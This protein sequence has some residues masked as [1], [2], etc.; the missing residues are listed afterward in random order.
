MTANRLEPVGLSVFVVVATA[1]VSPAQ[2]TS[3]SLLSGNTTNPVLSGNSTV[4]PARSE[5]TVSPSLPSSGLL[6][7]ATNGT[8]QLTGMPCSGP[9]ALS[10]SGAGGLP[11]HGAASQR[12][13]G[14]PAIADIPERVRSGQHVGCVLA[15]SAAATPARFEPHLEQGC[16]GDRVI[17]TFQESSSRG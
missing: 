12:G 10:V 2:N 3:N 4:L 14:K 7:N 15:N 9:G 1:T 13:L 5:L 16:M 17:F 6:S 11:G 8:N